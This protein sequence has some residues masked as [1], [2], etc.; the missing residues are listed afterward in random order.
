MQA[1]SV[2]KSGMPP[3]PDRQR[4]EPIPAGKPRNAGVAVMAFMILPPSLEEQFRAQANTLN[5]HAVCS[6]PESCSG[7]KPKVCAQ[8]RTRKVIQVTQCLETVGL[9]VCSSASHVN[10]RSWNEFLV[11]IWQPVQ[12]TMLINGIYQSFRPSLLDEGSVILKAEECIDIKTRMSTLEDN[13]RNRLISSSND[14]KPDLRFG[15][16]QWSQRW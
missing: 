8:R 1:L 12:G 15:L 10:D 6:T 16:L 4:G 13:D 3:S 9:P 14:R 7:L 2:C 5:F 11:L